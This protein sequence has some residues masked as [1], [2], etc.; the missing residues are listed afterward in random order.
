MCTRS[1]KIARAAPFFSPTRSPIA[2]PRAAR[3]TVRHPFARLQK[4]D[5]NFALHDATCRFMR[6]SRFRFSIQSALLFAA[7]TGPSF[8]RASAADRISI[9]EYHAVGD[10]KTLNTAAIQAAIDRA[11]SN[12]SGTI[13]IPP[14]V[15]VS[16]ALF[17]KPG[18]NLYLA[19]GAVLQCSTDLKNFPEQPTWIEG[20]LEPAF[21]SGLI[22]A[23]DCDGLHITGA[24]TLDGAGRPIWDLFWKLRNAAKDRKNFRNLCVPRAQLAIISHS[25]NVVIDGI[26]FKDS[27]FWNLHLYYCENVA[28]QHARFVVPDDYKQAPSTDGID[29]DCSKDVTVSHCLFSVTD[30]CIAAKGPKGPDARQNKNGAP[31]ERIHVRNCT[32]LRGGAALTCGSEASVVREVTVENCEIRGS[33]P[34]LQ[35]KLRPDTPQVYENIEAR[36]ITLAN[37][38]GLLLRIAPWSQYANTKGQPPPQSIVGHLR[39]SKIKGRTKSFARIEPNP[40]QT[41]ITD[42]QFSDIE[43]TV[44]KNPL[45]ISPAVRDLAFMNVI[46]NG[47]P[48]SPAAPKIPE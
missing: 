1:A 24:G 4:R 40:G 17:F 42:V 10:G 36:N 37:E 11:A 31:T 15:F 32:F 34:V 43:I 13:S 7:M 14:G 25:K 20:H 18:V 6:P 35:I 26:T 16:G 45:A 3:L 12:G 29:I 19:K 22:N 46:V 21:N 33:M 41:T 30:D 2:L 23:R 39:L 5:L 48:L 47:K 38:S 8:A 28:V 27:Q 44:E 9:L